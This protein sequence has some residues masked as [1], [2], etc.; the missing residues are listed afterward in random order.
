MRRTLAVLFMLVATLITVVDTAAADSSRTSAPDRGSVAQILTC[1]AG[2]LCAWPVT[3][4]SSNRCSW[5]NADNDWWNAPV[6]C[7]WSSGRPVKAIYNNGQSTSFTGVILY[8]GANYTDPA[9]CVPRGWAMTDP[10]GWGIIRSHRW[11]SGPC[12]T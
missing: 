4:G 9:V 12:P 3:D 11:T 2:N 8:H 7:S 1:S 6:T 10:D 5:S